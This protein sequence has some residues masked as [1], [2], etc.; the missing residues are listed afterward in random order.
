VLRRAGHMFLQT[1]HVKLKSVCTQLKN[2]YS[3]ADSGQELDIK[4]ASGSIR[5]PG[6]GTYIKLF[7]ANEKICVAFNIYD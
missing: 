3:S 5:Y 6:L 2:F 7:N 4:I 1:L